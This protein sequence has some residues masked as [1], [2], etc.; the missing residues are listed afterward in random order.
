MNN[1]LPNQDGF[2]GQFGGSFV[3]ELLNPI[4]KEVK[5]KFY[6]L[7]ET[8]EFAKELEYYYKQYIG[9]PSPLY[10]AEKLTKELGGCK[11]Y[12]K[13]ECLNHTGSHKINN[14]VGQALVAK[15]LVKNVLLQ[16]RGQAS[17]ELQRRRHVRS[18]TWNALSIWEL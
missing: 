12:L 8:P 10:F 16:K 5:E 2:F 6:E 4:L 3:P 7:K 15:A 13:R 9:R 11:V 1:T 18:L 14:T 17:T